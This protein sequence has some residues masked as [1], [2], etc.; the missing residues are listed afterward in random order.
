MSKLTAKI[1]DTFPALGFRN[2]RLFWFGQMISLIGTWM[3]NIGQAWLVLELTD[4]AFKL[5]LVSALQFLPM[6]LFSLLAGPLADRFPKRKL[7]LFT[8]SGFMILALILATLTYLGW[9]EYW[10]VLVLAVLLGLINTL[11]VPVRQSFI[12]ELVDRQ[13]LMSAI[14]LN[15]TIFNLARVIGP[16]VAGLLIGLLGIAICFYLNA[17]SFCAVILGIFAIKVEYLPPEKRQYN[18][19]ADIKEGLTFIRATPIVFYPIVLLAFISTF[20]MNYNV[21]V[22][23][24]ARESLEQNA[25]GFG[26]LM[27]CLG[28]GSLL[29]ALTLAANSKK[30]PK[31][32]VLLTAAMGTSFFLLVLSLERN[33][34]L[35][36][37]TLMVIGF[38][39]I[40][41]V[42][43][44][45]TTI[46]LNSANHMRGRVMSVYSL[47]VLG[48][49]P[50][51]SL[52]IG[53]I[54]EKFGIHFSMYLCAA[55]GIL[56]TV[57]VS[58][59][60]YRQKTRQPC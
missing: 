22:P 56:A 33:Y 9:I 47:V 57:A 30:G 31:T 40:T 26:L 45:N 50:V 23:V 3:Q 21:M 34:L 24:Y 7:L 32:K 44:V 48:L 2:Y 18:I 38:C 16:A 29:G 25:L 49:G 54:A 58:W 19:L 1:T 37:L 46:Q 35:S 15:S 53:D 28:I 10:H 6:T 55:I 4:S 8:Q 36:C 12:S 43:S 5:G 27:T 14:A 59:M 42:A 60:F 39:S 41:F 11:D 17:L 51:G 52:I 13:S 20:A